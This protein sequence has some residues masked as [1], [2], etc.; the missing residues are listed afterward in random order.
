MDN[1]VILRGNVGRNDPVFRYA[2]DSSFSMCAFTMATHESYRKN[3]ETVTQTEWHRIV[4]RNKYLEGVCK[5]I[6]PGTRINVRGKIKTRKYQEGD[7]TKSITEIVVDFD[8]AIDVCVTPPKSDR[9]PPPETGE[10]Q[11]KDSIPF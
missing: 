10:G 2:E 5:M 1:Q 8:G 11:P 7:V 3:N 4:V 6:A 9:S